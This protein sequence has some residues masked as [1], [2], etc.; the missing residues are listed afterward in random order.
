MGFWGNIICL[1]IVLVFELDFFLS[2]CGMYV[3][4]Y[5]FIYPES[6]LLMDLT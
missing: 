1:F 3:N 5:G 4:I 6:S 2:Y